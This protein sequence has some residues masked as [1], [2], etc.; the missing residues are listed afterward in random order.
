MTP[1]R[2]V[3]SSH[4]EC[5][6]LWTCMFFA[7]HST[8]HT[9]SFCQWRRRESSAKR[10]ETFSQHASRFRSHDK[11][12]QPYVP[13]V[14]AELLAPLRC[15]RDRVHLSSSRNGARATLHD[16]FRK[17]PASAETSTFRGRSIQPHHRQRR[18]LPRRAASF[19]FFHNIERVVHRSC[20][21]RDPLTFVC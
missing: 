6:G 17:S 1:R 4:R 13:D 8:V 2:R 18:S 20:L 16:I 7:G 10:I 15:T 19:L 9:S 3:S 5:R 11:L 21:T 12:M 14:P